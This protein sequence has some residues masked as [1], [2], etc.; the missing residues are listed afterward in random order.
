M[1]LL[2]NERTAKVGMKNKRLTASW[3]DDYLL[4]VLF[5]P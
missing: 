3:N 2:K 5:R 4:K 1:G